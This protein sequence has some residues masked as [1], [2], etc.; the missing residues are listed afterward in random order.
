MADLILHPEVDFLECVFFEDLNRHGVLLVVTESFLLGWGHVHSW[1]KRRYSDVIMGAMAYQIT[2]LTIVYSTVYSGT[3]QRK[4]QSSVSLAF[5][6]G[7]HRWPVNSPH[8]WPV[9]PSWRTQACMLSRKEQRNSTVSPII[10]NKNDLTFLI[11]LRVDIIEPCQDEVIDEAHIS[12]GL[13]QPGLGGFLDADRACHDDVIKWKHFQRYWP[14]VRG[15]HRWPVNSPHKGQWRGAFD[16]FFDLRLNKRFSKRSRRPWFEMPSRSLWRHD[17]VVTLS[18]QQKWWRI[19]I[20]L[21]LLKWINAPRL[22]QRHTSQMRKSI[23]GTR[24]VRRHFFF[25]WG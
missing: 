5:V 14:F 23:N 24:R 9:T 13:V 12:Q 3:D 6:R 19:N 20:T 15:I 1:R 21:Q 2:S 8:E 4:H 17:N 18:I 16:V 7:F 10:V 11:H 22:I 25:T